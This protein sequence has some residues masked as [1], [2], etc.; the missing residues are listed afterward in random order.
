MAI[1]MAWAGNGVE[2]VP[3]GPA[4]HHA[5]EDAPDAIGNAIAAILDAPPAR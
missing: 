5:P 2:V 4:G 3:L 1:G